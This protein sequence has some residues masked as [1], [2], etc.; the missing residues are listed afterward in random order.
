M[1]AD[2]VQTGFGRTGRL[3]ACERYGIAPDLLVSAKSMGGGMPLAAVTGRAE[4][5]DSPKVGGLGGT[6]GGNPLSS[7]L[8]SPCSN[9]EKDNLSARAELLGEFTSRAPIGSAAAPSSAR[10]ADWAGCGAGARQ[11]ARNSRARQTGNRTNHP[12][13]LRTR[14]AGH[15][16]RHLRQRHSPSRASGDFRRRFRRGARCAEGA[17]SAVSET[18]AS[19][20][21]RH[22]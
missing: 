6:F 12:I 8:R 14:L 2:E 1:I 3:F 22:A 13:L 18:H 5:M 21:T 10:F 20:E 4:I 19:A 9:D 16:S 7:P 15:L 17:L 11:F